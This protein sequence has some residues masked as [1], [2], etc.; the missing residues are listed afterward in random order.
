[1]NV[2]NLGIIYEKLL[3]SQR[4]IV[5]CALWSNGVIGSYFIENSA[6]ETVSVFSIGYPP[7]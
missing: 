2:K 6:G 7:F 1:M 3:D 5:W 4:I